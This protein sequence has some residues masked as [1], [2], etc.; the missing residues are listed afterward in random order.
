MFQ[1]GIAST[2]IFWVIEMSIV[3]RP[4]VLDFAGTFLDHAPDFSE[5]VMAEWE[6]EKQEQFGSRWR[7]A[8]AIL[9]EFEGFGIF[10]V[11]VNP[12]N[13]SFGDCPALPGSSYLSR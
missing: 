1:N 7:D 13:I 9:R 12:G 8:Q 11:D 4:F 5:E 6:A 2:T 10:I 3:K